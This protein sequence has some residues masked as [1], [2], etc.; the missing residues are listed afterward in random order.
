MLRLVR[1]GGKPK[2]LMEIL[3]NERNEVTL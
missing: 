2:A 1:D 3:E